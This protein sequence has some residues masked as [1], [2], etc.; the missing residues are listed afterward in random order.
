LGPTWVTQTEKYRS[1]YTRPSAPTATRPRAPSK[2]FIDSDYLIF[3]ELMGPSGI[4]GRFNYLLILTI[5]TLE[6]Q[7][8]PV[9]VLP[10]GE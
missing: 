1:F 9:Y 2:H 3:P 4:Q 8:I 10:R 6:S 5:Q 7:E